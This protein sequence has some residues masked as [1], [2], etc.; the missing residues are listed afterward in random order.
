VPVGGTPFTSRIDLPP[1]A[2]L[3]VEGHISVLAGHAPT[4]GVATGDHGDGPRLAELQLCASRVQSVTALEAE[5]H[6][7]DNRV[8]WPVFG[9]LRTLKM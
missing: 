9:R 1:L 8:G 5:S 4:A 2:R 7:A 3:W 6:G